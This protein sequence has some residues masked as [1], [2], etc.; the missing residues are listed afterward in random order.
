MGQSRTLAGRLTS[1]HVDK[2]GNNERPGGSEARWTRE[3][4]GSKGNRKPDSWL[5]MHF[6]VSGLGDR[7]PGSGL[8][9]R[10]QVQD[11]NF[12]RHPHLYLYLNT[13]ARDLR[14]ETWDLRIS[15]MQDAAMS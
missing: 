10:V 9:V 8:Q 4:Q 5:G 2:G 15:V 3:R 7:E 13:R 11:L 14:A 6:Q 12:T 1:W